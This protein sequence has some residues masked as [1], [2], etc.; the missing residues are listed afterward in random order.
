MFYI[1]V[2]VGIEVG[3]CVGNNTVV[4]GAGVVVVVVV[5][6]GVVWVVAACV[7]VTLTLTTVAFGSAVM[8]ESVVV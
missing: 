3:G 7:G 5:G 8:F 1:P 2:S 4:V 6:V